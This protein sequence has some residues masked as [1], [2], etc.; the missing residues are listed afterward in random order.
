MRRSPA[1]V[2]MVAAMMMLL[3]RCGGN[4]HKR[5]DKGGYDKETGHVL[6][7]YFHY[8]SDSSTP[9]HSPLAKLLRNP[10]PLFRIGQLAV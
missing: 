8:F 2:V 4:R 5:Q 3:R 1:L 7:P 9:Q 10:R 6:S